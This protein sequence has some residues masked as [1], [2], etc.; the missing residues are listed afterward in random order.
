M[1]I[2]SS[3]IDLLNGFKYSSEIHDFYKNKKVLV[4]G[5]EGFLG[6]NSI[7]AFLLLVIVLLIL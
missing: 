2:N 5:P 7:F 1:D 6:L 4:V 3:G